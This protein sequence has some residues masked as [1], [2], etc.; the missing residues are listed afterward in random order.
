LRRAAGPLLERLWVF[1]E[2]RGAPLPAGT[3]SVGWRL[4]FREEGRTLREAEVDAVL[5]Q[6]LNQVEQSHGARRRE[7]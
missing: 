5:S 1:D 4:V 6:T 3:R 7:N 2:Y